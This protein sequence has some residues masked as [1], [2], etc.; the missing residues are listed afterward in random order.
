VSRWKRF[1]FQHRHQDGNGATGE[2]EKQNPA[3]IQ[4]GNPCPRGTRRQTS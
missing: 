3:G 4:N 1:S 2:K